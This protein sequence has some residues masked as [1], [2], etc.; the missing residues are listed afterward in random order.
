MG[1][2]QCSRWCFTLNNF[3]VGVD[4]KKIFSDVRNNIRRC[5]WGVEKGSSGTNHLQGYIEF[6]RSYRISHLKVILPRAHFEAARG[7][8]KQ[9]YEYC[10]KDGSFETFGD[11]EAV[12]KSGCKRRRAEN[13]H[14]SL[15]L[16]LLGSDRESFK[17]SLQ[18]I[19][20]KSAYDE[21][22]RELSD[23]S[24][25]IERFGKYSSKLLC[26]WQMSILR[27]LFH[28]NDRQILW[29][30]SIEG[31]F[32]KSFL[33]HFL[34][35]VYDY[36]LFDGVTRC[37]DIAHMLSVS[38]SGIVFDVTR[39]DASHFAYSTMESVKNGYVSSG[40]YKGIKRMFNSVPVIV[41]A[42]FE[43]VRSRLSSDRLDIVC[44]DG[45]P[46]KKKNPTYSP[47]EIWAFKTPPALPKVEEDVPVEVSDENKSKRAAVLSG[48]E[49]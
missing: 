16:G 46:Q 37:N 8:A 23:I 44:L 27:R 47:A 6:H 40:K 7:N 14:K 36:E 4:Y 48:I 9:N 21:R 49:G 19:S 41:F 30:Y 43:P 33:A 22:I 25:R 28:Q 13:E 20:R 45:L 11:W 10:T 17:N 3:E 15:L 18:Y 39:D 42:N 2:A 24:A 12:L 5:V 26:G 31:G 35:S 1:G 34:N 32:G 38:F 29:V